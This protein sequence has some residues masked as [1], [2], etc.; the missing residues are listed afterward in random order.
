M[1][2]VTAL[3]ALALFLEG[4]SMPDGHV[5]SDE[6]AQLQFNT[7]V[8]GHKLGL[9]QYLADQGYKHLIDYHPA[10]RF[11]DFQGVEAGGLAVLSI[12]LLV[13]AVWLVCRRAA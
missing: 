1:L 13:L 12:A 5:L 3:S 9:E 11:W 10:S 6:I 8:G 2:A 4:R 7:S